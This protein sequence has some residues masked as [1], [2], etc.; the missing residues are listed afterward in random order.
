MLET[1]DS[2][3][4]HAKPFF[5]PDQP[6]RGTTYW[7]WRL[8]PILDE[9]STVEMLLFYLADVSETERRKRDLKASLQELSLILDSA[10]S[11]KRRAWA[12]FGMA[13]RLDGTGPW[14]AR[15]TANKRFGANRGGRDTGSDIPVHPGVVV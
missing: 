5:H 9:N 2:F 13:G 11:E 15:Y 10:V 14:A 6:E 1:G 4:V 12:G 3:E 7:D 8:E